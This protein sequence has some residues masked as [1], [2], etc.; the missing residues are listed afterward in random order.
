MVRPWTSRP[1]ALAGFSMLLSTP[2]SATSSVPS[3]INYIKG[4]VTSGASH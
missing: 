4:Q 2:L 3:S 1:L